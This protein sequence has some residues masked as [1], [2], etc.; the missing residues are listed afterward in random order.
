MSWLA[1][2]FLFLSYLSHFKLDFNGVEDNIYLL[3]SFSLSSYLVYD[4]C[5]NISAKFKSDFNGV[6]NKV[7]GISWYNLTN[8]LASIQLIDIILSSLLVQIQPS[9]IEMYLNCTVRPSHPPAHP[10]KYQRQLLGMWDLGWHFQIPTRLY[11]CWLLNTIQLKWGEGNFN[12]VW[13]RFASTKAR[14]L[15]YFRLKVIRL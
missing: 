15:L 8:Y 11:N 2:I 10:G 14:I 12:Q 13:L 1:T 5:D 4:I 7:C 6:K 9:L 3:N